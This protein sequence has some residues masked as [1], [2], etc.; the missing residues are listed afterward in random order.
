[1][2]ICN[3][4]FHGF[5]RFLSM[6]IQVML[7]LYTQFLLL[8]S[9]GCFS[10]LLDSKTFPSRARVFSMHFIYLNIFKLYGL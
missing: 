2:I 9:S 6:V 4:N 8:S 3:I 1:M 5:R 7:F 10:W